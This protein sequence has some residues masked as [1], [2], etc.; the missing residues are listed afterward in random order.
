MHLLFCEGYSELQDGYQIYIDE[1]YYGVILLI[2]L[3]WTASTD[4]QLIGVA[5]LLSSASS[6][7]SE[8]LQIG[9][10]DVM[11]IKPTIESLFRS[12]STWVTGDS[13]KNSKSHNADCSPPVL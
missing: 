3:C 8:D 10:K 1:A 12:G 9:C 7:G 6:E 5:H 4:Q 13:A 11:Q 2:I